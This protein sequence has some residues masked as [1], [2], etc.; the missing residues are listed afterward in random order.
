[1]RN[2]N[3]F[4]KGELAEISGENISLRQHIEELV[5]T[6]NNMHSKYSIIHGRKDN[7]GSHSH[8]E[9]SSATLQLPRLDI[10]VRHHHSPNEKGALSRRDELKVIANK[11]NDMLEQY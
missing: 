6:M 2:N 5:L 8:V 9:P 3:R 10:G 1:M 4:L 11:Q 7:H